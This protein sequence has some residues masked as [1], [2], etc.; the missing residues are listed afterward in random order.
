MTLPNRIHR[1]SGFFH[2]EINMNKLLVDRKNLSIAMCYALIKT[3]QSTAFFIEAR[4]GD[5][6]VQFLGVTFMKISVCIAVLITGF[7]VLPSIA[8]AEDGPDRWDVRDVASDDTLNMRAKPAASSKRVARIPHNAKG[9]EN[10][11]CRGGPTLA[12]FST[13]SETEQ[14]AAFG[15]RWCQ[16]SYKGK[17]G[18][19]SAR[20]LIESAE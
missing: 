7:A 15:R 14:A 3:L 20:F 2:A 12:E 19:V 18:W 9:L 11:G 6:W 1:Q 5:D 4:S 10:F 8:L 13:M 17:K 16:V